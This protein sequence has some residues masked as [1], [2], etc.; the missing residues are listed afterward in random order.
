[1][2][3][4]SFFEEF[5]TKN[6]L[7]KLNLINF[8]TKLYLAAK[9]LQE[10]SQIKSTIKNKFI[11]EFVYWPILEIKEGY[12]IS[13]FT[14]RRALKRIFNE[15]NNNPTSTMLDLEWPLTKNPLLFFTQ[16]INFPR[17]KKLIRNF[18]DNHKGKIHLCEYYPEGKKK[19]W[20]L[21]K[22]GLHYNNEKAK[23][24]KM[25]YHSMHP[26]FNK[27]FFRKELQR[28]KELHQDNFIASFGTIASGMKGNEPIL[29][30]EQ[31]NQDLKIAKENNI[32]EVIIFRLGGLDKEYLK[33]IRKYT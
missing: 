22:M 26:S 7:N 25:F 1:M 3:L 23:I 33:I 21:E 30:K 27:D 6:N 15:L 24:I 31:L 13:P 28:G 29:T 12:W 19:D 32:Q 11:K 5:P 14:K 18:I 20:F 2:M 10:F 9:S 17:N 4:I 8:P 16:A